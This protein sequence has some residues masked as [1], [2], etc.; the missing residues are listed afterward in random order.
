MEI[1]VVVSTM[2]EEEA[3]VALV[4]MEVLLMDKVLVEMD[5]IIVIQVLHMEEEELP[6]GQMEMEEDLIHIYQEV[7]VVVVLEVD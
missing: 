7:V 6:D 3:L 2:V 4:V 1:R 5:I